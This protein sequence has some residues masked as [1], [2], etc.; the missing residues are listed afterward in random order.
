MN[1]IYKLLLLCGLLV[2]LNMGLTA[3]VFAAAEAKADT[4]ELK[5]ETVTLTE[6]DRYD[7]KYYKP[8]RSLYREPSKESARG[9]GK[10]ASSALAAL[11]QAL[12]QGWAEHQATIDLTGCR[13]HVN[14]IST[15][16]FQ[17]L[18]SHE[19][20]F[21]VSESCPYS[22]DPSTGLVAFVKPVY[23]MSRAEAEAAS[24]KIRAAV[25]EAKALISGDMA[26]YEKALIIHDWLAVACEYDKENLDKGRVPETSH[27]IAGALG[28]KRAVCDG[29]AK[30]YQYIMKQL[31]IPCYMTSSSGMAHAWNLLQ[32]GSGCYHVDVTWDDPTWDC[33]GRACHDYFLLS[34]ETIQS[35][36]RP[37]YG[38]DTE[39]KA[40][41]KSYENACWNNSDSSLIYRGGYWYYTDSNQKK[42]MKTQNLLRGGGEA[43]Y[44]LGSWRNAVGTWPG[45]FSCLQAY[46]DRLIFNGPKA[47]YSMSFADEKVTELYRPAETAGPAD[48]IFGFKINGN[49]MYYAIQQDPNLNSHQRAYIK[50]A[51]IPGAA[52]PSEPEVPSEPEPEEPAVPEKPSEPVTPPAPEEPVTPPSQEEPANPT[53]P[54]DPA[55]PETPPADKPSSP[56]Q[57]K[58]G[59]VI[60]DAKTNGIYKVTKIGSKTGSNTVTYQKPVNKN[61][62]SVVIPASVKLSGTGYQVTKIA[63]NAFK[64]N[65]KIK[66]VRLGTNLQSIGAN[67]FRKCTGIKSI[68]IPSGVKTIQKGA[69]ASCG[70]LKT[71]TIKT[72][73]LSKKTVGANAFKGIPAKAT[74]KVPKGK[75]KE[76]K[77]LL[78]SRGLNRK[79]KIK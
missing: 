15:Q 46:G 8:L 19:E 18:N 16:Y 1:R 4:K 62:T 7:P 54:A 64:N 35:R 72:A 77:K 2:L 68:S 55:E 26:D 56:A 29:Y 78:Q 67:A 47:I 76:Y 73:K 42:L 43:V 17:I 20:Y 33:I 24:E 30:S 36:E 38:W 14:D 57:I 25:A 23:S 32:L 63:D 27:S 12:T 50:T 59:S 31:G 40:S 6:A 75:V 70:N 13:V 61:K 37:H 22:Y 41:D 3:N 52:A 58:V 65:S 51:S 79:V 45:V 44:E 9:L 39:L 49:Q 5:S 60:R 28:E 74:V 48:N 53:Q 69:F 66:S 21:W 34:D 71:I 10:A 11:E